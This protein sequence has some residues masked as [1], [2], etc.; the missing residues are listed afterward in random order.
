MDLPHCEEI[1]LVFLK[2]RKAVFQSATELTGKGRKREK[3]IEFINKGAAALS[4]GELGTK[5]RWQRT[6]R[7]EGMGTPLR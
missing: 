4:A 1:S 7:E 5:A 6:K 2:Q 3:S